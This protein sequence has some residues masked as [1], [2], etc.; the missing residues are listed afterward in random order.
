LDGKQIISDRTV[1]VFCRQLH[2][3]A[4]AFLVCLLS[5]STL[6]GHERKR[7]MNV[8]DE[9]DNDFNLNGIVIG[10]PRQPS[11]RENERPSGL[12]R[13]FSGLGPRGAN[14]L[15]EGLLGASG[16]NPPTTYRAKAMAFAEVSEIGQPAAVRG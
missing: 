15:D 14:S 3:R 1:D 9:I 13:H 8:A 6:P 12:A 2:G 7:F 5:S 11:S 10:D 16:A 4:T